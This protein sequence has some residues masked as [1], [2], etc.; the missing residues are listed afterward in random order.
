LE[1]DHGFLFKGDIY[2]PGSQWPNILGLPSQAKE[3]KGLPGINP[4][5][6]AMGMPGGISKRYPHE[7]NPMI[8]P[9]G[10]NT[11]G[12]IKPA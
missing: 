4:E 7:E 12:Q 1:S 6:S 11:V 2:L 8:Y 10:V 5:Y 3:T 9:Y